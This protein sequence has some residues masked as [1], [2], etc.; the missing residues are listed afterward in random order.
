MKFIMILQCWLSKSTTTVCWNGYLSN[1]VSLTCGVRQGGILSPFLFSVYVDDVLVRLHSLKVG[2][3][4]HFINFN[5]MM[6]ADD[7]ILLAISLEDLQEMINVCSEEFIKLDM[8][9]NAKKSCCMRVGKR[10]NSKVND[11]LIDQAAIP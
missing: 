3:H 10:F 4:I 1:M 8:K 11:I 2:C 5:S 6:Y 9:P 7:L